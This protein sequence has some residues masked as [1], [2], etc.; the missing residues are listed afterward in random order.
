MPSSTRRPAESTAIRVAWRYGRQPV[1]HH[2]RR[3][4]AHEPRERLLH[5]G[6]GF[7]IERRG[8][9]VQDEDARIADEG[10]GHG[11]TLPL[12]ARQ[13]RAALADAG[14]T[15]AGNRSTNSSALASASACRSR[16]GDTSPA[17]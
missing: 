1:R 5:E 12:T 6:L 3:A 4:A 8:G 10:P 13:A 17:P 15:P 14:S 2:H 11:Q 9:L 7:A 16:S